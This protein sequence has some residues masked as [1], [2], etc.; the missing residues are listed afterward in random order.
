M[1]FPGTARFQISITRNNITSSS[2]LTP[3]TL[4]S[5]IKFQL[6]GGDLVNDIAST[7]LP[8]A[9]M[10]RGKERTGDT[11]SKVWSR[12]HRIAYLTKRGLQ[13]QP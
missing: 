5:P 4:V 2:S 9:Y 3:C 1:D 7:S 8:D 6:K 13:G 11:I 12:Q 10:G